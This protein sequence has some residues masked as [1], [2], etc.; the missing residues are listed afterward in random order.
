M[1]SKILVPFFSAVA[2]AGAVVGA[3]H[4]SPAF[5]SKVVA[6]QPRPP[7]V[8]HAAQN[9]YAGESEDHF[10]NVVEDIEEDIQNFMAKRGLPSHTDNSLAGIEQREDDKFVYIDVK[11]D[12]VESTAINTRIDN[13]QVSVT[14]SVERKGA[15]P[16]EESVFQSTF[17][18]SFPVPENVDA[19]KMEIDTDQNRYV[20]KFPKVKV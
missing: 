19:N 16:F 17:H 9:I 7:K 5:K 2:G 18:K 12:N 3:V 13:G 14:G 6:E 15:D 8:V 20:L 10:E 11:V 4:M 1:L